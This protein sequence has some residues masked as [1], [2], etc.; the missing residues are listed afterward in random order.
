VRPGNRIDSLANGDTVTKLGV[1]S[2]PE[3]WHVSATIQGVPV[4]GFVAKKYLQAISQFT[5]QATFNGITAVHLRENWANITRA[6]INGRAYPLGEGGR[7]RRQGATPSAQ[8]SSLGAI[9][10]WLNVEQSPRYDP[11]SI[12][13]YCNIYAY[14]YCYLA[15]VYIPRVWWTRSAIQTLAQGGAV[16]P[17]WNATVSELNAN[18]LYRW[19]IEFSPQFG[20]QRTFDLTDLQNT[21]NQGGIGIICAQR[22]DLNRSGHI[23]AVVP[24]TQSQQ[25]V[26]SGTSVI[27]PLQSQAGA[28]NFKYVN[29]PR[30]WWTDAKFSHYGFWKHA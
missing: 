15:G 19:F 17:Q 1:A 25:A 29:G 13:T 24:E 8:A 6:N 23:V 10:S 14:D 28:E 5:P 4:E 26:R 11:T 7:P 9:L 16:S 21:A 20:W 18:N 22:A 3:W 30:A 2:D 12:H 27:R